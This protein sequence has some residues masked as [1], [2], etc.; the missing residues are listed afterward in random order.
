MKIDNENTPL[1]SPPDLVSQNPILYARVLRAPRRHP[2]SPDKVLA[3]TSHR[4]NQTLPTMI[5]KIT[6]LDTTVQRPGRVFSYKYTVLGLSAARLNKEQIRA[7]IE[8][9]LFHNYKT[10]PSMAAL[11]KLS[12]ILKYSYFD[13]AGAFILDIEVDPAR[14]TASAPSAN[15]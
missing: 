1:F 5:D 6:R 11:R 3:N 8:P 2:T 4:L 15:S 13:E 10:N 9:T 7:A 14:F 12:A